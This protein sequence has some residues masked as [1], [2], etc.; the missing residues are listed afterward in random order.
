MFSK[1]PASQHFLHILK[2]ASLVFQFL[3]SE[4][5]KASKNITRL[6]KSLME[7]QHESSDCFQ[8]LLAPLKELCGSAPHQ[9]LFFPWGSEEGILNKLRNYM[10]VFISLKGHSKELLEVQNIIEKGA[11]E[12]F[13]ALELVKEAELEKTSLYFRELIEKHLKVALRVLKKLP[14]II[15][16]LLLQ[17]KKDENVLFFLLR[18]QN[19]FCE[20]YS[21]RAL[22]DFFEKIHAQGLKGVN[23]YM[24][25]RYTRRG[26]SQLAKPISEQ[27]KELKI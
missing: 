27:F 15:F 14:K 25:K 8:K 22:R 2:D 13:S 11:K 12:A 18:F 19:E 26:F 10:H 1:Q 6:E 16:S 3:L 17:F 5:F 20:I 24:V 9:A 21:K 4:F 23:N 7:Y